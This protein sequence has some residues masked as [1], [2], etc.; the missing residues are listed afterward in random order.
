MGGELVRHV[1]DNGGAEVTEGELPTQKQKRLYIG[2]RQMFS[3]AQPAKASDKQDAKR[4][5]AFNTLCL[6]LILE[7]P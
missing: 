7:N 4:A 6:T 3:I 1:R 2:I 5:N